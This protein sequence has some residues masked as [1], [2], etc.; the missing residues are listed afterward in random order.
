MNATARLIQVIEVEE[1][2]GAGTLPDP[3]RRVTVYFDTDGNFLAE[4]DRWLE[5]H[6]SE[7]SEIARLGGI[8]RAESLSPERRSEIAREAANARWTRPQA[9]GEPA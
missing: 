7:R 3:A 1:T 4:R 5:E 9:E 6:G 2:R 8:A